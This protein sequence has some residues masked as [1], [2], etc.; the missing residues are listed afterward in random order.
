MTS[1]NP[2][3]RIG[4]QLA[5]AISTHRPQMK[6]E[7]VRDRVIH[8]LE[9]VG[10]PNAD[11]RY[12][13][14]PHEFSGGMRQR[15]MIAMA[16]R[17][18]AGAAHRGRADDGARRDDPG[19][20]RC[21]AQGRRGG[22]ATPACSSS[23]TTSA[24]SPRFAQKVAVMYAGRSSS[25]GQSREVF[26]DPQH[27]YTRRSPAAPSR[28]STA[29]RVERLRPIDG[30]PPDLRNMPPGCPFMPRCSSAGDE[31][32]APALP[33]L[34]ARRRGRARERCLAEGFTGTAT[35]LPRRGEVSRVSVTRWPERRP[36]SRSTSGA[37]RPSELLDVRGL[38]KHFPIRGGLFKRKHRPG[39]RRRWRRLHARGRQD[40]RLVG[41]SG[42]RQD[43]APAACSCRLEEP[44]DGADRHRRP[45]H[46]R[47]LARQACASA[48]GGECRSSS[49]TRT[50][51]W[52]RACP[53][54]TSSPS[55]WTC[56]ASAARR[57]ARTA[58]P[59]AGARRPQPGARAA[60]SRTSS[61]AASAS[62]SAS[63]GR[64]R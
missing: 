1:L 43:D 34:T 5:E 7:Q 36:S 16:R 57:P 17:E 38:K 62:A 56:R 64:S 30:S 63:P 61:P 24:W 20:D 29:R 45:G 22:D 12:K 41:E 54:A 52:T 48:T 31:P 28:P 53:S 19:A 9:L 42:L 37:G 14:Y 11:A 2:V 40:A 35:P 4:N 46:H 50:R 58:S 59:A 51:R 13:Q 39:A 44:T 26:A 32:C 23:R 3:L 21:A 27:P 60:A 33:D 6:R 15:V 8:L 10:I 55:R 49:R 47:H 25:T 18:R